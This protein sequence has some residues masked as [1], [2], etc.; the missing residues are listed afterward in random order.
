MDTGI[1]TPAGRAG[2]GTPGAAR[3]DRQAT[4]AVAL[5]TGWTSRAEGL[6]ERC[7][8][9]EPP[10]EQHSDSAQRLPV[11]PKP[12]HDELDPKLWRRIRHQ[13]TPARASTG[14]ASRRQ[15]GGGSSG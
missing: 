11:A 12:V 10:S 3:P 8:E 15:G 5:E 7:G 14:Q 4:T 9:P 1:P 2:A 13:A 6:E